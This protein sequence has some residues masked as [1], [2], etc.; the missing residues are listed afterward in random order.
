[1]S[2]LLAALASLSLGLVLGPE[3]PLIALGLGLPPLILRLIGK[4]G[5]NERLLALAGAFA[6]LA[7]L[8]GGPLVAALLFFELV[9]ESEAI[10]ARQLGQALLPGLRRGGN[11]R[12]RLHRRGRLGGAPPAE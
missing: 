10:P 8:F 9:A 11:G 6:A 3:A 2:I 5:A 4:H 7:A 12:A 1:M